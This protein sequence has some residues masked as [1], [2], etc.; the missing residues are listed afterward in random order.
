MSSHSSIRSF[1]ALFSLL[2]GL[3]ATAALAQ[4]TQFTYQGYLQES[5]LAAN[6][7]YDFQF[8]LYDAITGGTQQGALLIFDDVQVTN[9]LFKVALD[10]GQSVFPGANRFLEFSVRPGASSGVYTIL[11]PRQQINSTPYAIK[12]LTADSLSATCAGCVT[13]AQIAV[14]VAGAKITGAVANATN[15]SGILGGDVT[16]TQSATNVVALRGKAIAAAA[17]ANGQVLKFNTTSNQY[18]P[19]PDNS[20]G[21]ITQVAAG[22][23]LSGGGTNGSV[24]LNIA[25]SGVGTTQLADNSVTNAKIA[26][27]AGNKITG[28]ITFA[29]IPGANVSSPVASFS[30][31]LTGD[32]TG[33]QSTTNVVG[34]R[35]KVI[36]ATAPTNGQVLKFNTTTNQYEP[37]ADNNS[38][39]TVMNVTASA[40]LASSGGTAPAIS[41]SGVVPIANGGTGT[42][43]TPSAAGQFLRSTGS[44]T[45]G[46]SGLVVTD[47]ITG[48]PNYI[49]N[50]P[51]TTQ[52]NSNFNISG[53]GT[54][55]VITATTQY[56][57]NNSRVLSAA[58]GGNFFVGVGAG[59]ANPTG[60]DN[61]FFGV[62][63]GAATTSG[64]RNSFFGKDAGKA[65]ITTND[66]SFFGTRAG[67]VTTG[68]SNSFFGVNAGNSNQTGSNNV[69]LGYMAGSNNTTG[70]GNIYIGDQASGS[71]TLTNATAI[72]AG[73]SVTC[74]ACMVLGTAGGKVGV[75]MT[76]PQQS[77]SVIGGLNIDQADANN[78]SAA[79]GLTFGSNSGEGIASKRTAGMGTNQFG[80]D[81]YT[82]NINQMAITNGGNVKIGTT[83]PDQRLSVSGNASKS[84]G[85]MSWA[86]FSDERLKNIKGRF[87]PGLSVLMQLQPIRY[88]Y[89]PDNAL[90]LK[91]EGEAVGFSAQAVEKVLPEAVTRGAQGYL[92][93][94]GDPLLWTMLNAVKEQQGLIEQLKQEHTALR[95]RLEA[96]EKTRQRRG[97]Q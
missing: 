24:T 47:L 28:P 9:G 6:G 56:N 26:D 5:S 45:W 40:P 75:G 68:S 10:F 50:N 36:A 73:A 37:A 81:F 71:P 77:L 4:T 54:A 29:T 92:Q 93:L 8:K 59:A 16:G 52:A 31:A 22:T 41:L 66:N 19:A 3:G 70:N 88:E 83:M 57:L 95:Q 27:V 23:G 35:G 84:A 85:G 18:E 69:F 21:T 63:A 39:G 78:G 62:N 11:T 12:S 13:D 96:L 51:P 82:N 17:P 86:V 72:G 14:G 33:T 67:Q 91:G 1:L 48:S 34:L 7:T 46:V 74:S 87:T 38:G 61:S 90:G 79:N 53:N 25:N 15:F 49:Q 42:S 43:T 2:I 44:G 89:K 65:V 94:N 60:G 76:T 97:N 55:N 32:V 58:G 30:G 64:G 20:G 80:L